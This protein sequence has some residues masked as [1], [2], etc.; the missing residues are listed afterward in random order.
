[1]TTAAELV[2]AAS[3][4]VEHLDPDRFAAEAAR[5]NTVVVDV[6]EAE[7]RLG[8]TIAG[9][10][11]VPRGMLEFRA[12]PHSPHY[13][14][15]LH[16]DRGILLHCHSGARSVLAAAALRALGYTDVVHLEGGIQAWRSAGKPLVNEVVQPY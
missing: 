3:E 11:H 8:G 5:P 13:D 16:P 9:A 6:R 1:M 14:D 7:E 2:A 4:G 15:R 10:V 12:D